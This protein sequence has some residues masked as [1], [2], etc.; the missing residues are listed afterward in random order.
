MALA[1][2][3]STQ[4]QSEKDLKALLRRLV[5]DESETE[6]EDKD[7]AAAAAK[8]NKTNAPANEAVVSKIKDAKSASTASSKDVAASAIPFALGL[9][10]AFG[11]FSYANR[12]KQDGQRAIRRIAMEPLGSK[13]NLM[14]VEALGEY[15]LLATGGREP[16]LLAQLDTE[17]AKER[18]AALNSKDEPETRTTKSW[19]ASSG[20]RLK[21]LIPNRTP[22]FDDILDEAP[23]NVEP[24]ATKKKRTSQPSA[25]LALAQASLRALDTEPPAKKKSLNERLAELADEEN[26]DASAS[27]EDRADAIR[28]RLAS[29]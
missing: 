16:V 27:R 7:T 29:L 20:K 21:A 24:K 12:K 2:T 15:L 22:N 9:F 3:P 28:R 18:L 5:P 14:L 4:G 8:E 17:Q 13:Q 1:E 25:N 6:E 11:L 26:V 23:I 10:L 19:I